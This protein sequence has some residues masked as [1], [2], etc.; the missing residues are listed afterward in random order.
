MWV[1]FQAFFDQ[2][3][4]IIRHI[5][6]GKDKSLVSDQPGSF[7]EILFGIGERSVP[8]EITDKAIR[9]QQAWNIGSFTVDNQFR[10]GSVGCELCFRSS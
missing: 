1:E 10:G 9:I 5:A 8:Y 2:P 4:S 3:L 6:A 7:R